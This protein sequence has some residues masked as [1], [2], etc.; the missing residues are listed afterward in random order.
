MFASS[1]SDVRAG[2]HSG[3]VTLFAGLWGTGRTRAFAAIATNGMGARTGDLTDI[4][5]GRVVGARGKNRESMGNFTWSFG[6]AAGV[7]EAPAGERGSEYQIQREPCGAP[8]D[9]IGRGDRF[10]CAY[11][12]RRLAWSNRSPCSRVTQ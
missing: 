9:R 4:N 1:L 10:I 8:A 3:V 7:V 11:T 6:L 12:H 2:A 5:R